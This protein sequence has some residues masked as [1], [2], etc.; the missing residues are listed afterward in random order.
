MKRFNFKGRCDVCGR[1]MH[2]EHLKE[3]LAG[4]QINS[5]ELLVLQSY[6]KQL[7]HKGTKK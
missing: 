2:I 1:C 6:L 3:E 4:L 7:H 5:F